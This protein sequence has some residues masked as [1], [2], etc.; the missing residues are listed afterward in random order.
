MWEEIGQTRAECYIANVVKCRPPNNRDPAPNEIEA[1]RPY[2]AEQITLIDPVVIVTLGNF[3]TKLLLGS[4]RGIREL[5]GQVFERDAPS[6]SRRTTRPTSCAP[7][8]RPWPRCGPTSCERSGWSPRAGSE[9]ARRT[10]DRVARAPPA[11]WRAAWRRC[12]APVTS[13]CSSATSARARRCSPR[14]S[15]PRSAWPGPVTSPTFALVR[16]YRCGPGSPVSGLLHADVYRT[17]SVG[18]VADLALAELVEEDAVALVEWGDLAAPALGDSALEVTLV[19]PDPLAT[20]DR[21]TVT[22]VGRGRWARPGR[23]G[24]GGAGACGRDVGAV[25]DGARTCRRAAASTPRRWWPSR[26][27]RRPSGWPSGHLWA[28]RPSSR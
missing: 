8:A 17:G 10:T 23:R 6:S 28:W 19:A 25:S 13:S 26:R 4:T 9:L 12:A 3:S 16:H 1:C 27:R 18:E 22:I 20:P 14:A 21:R 11:R 15:P 2:L 7:A 5:R 24:G